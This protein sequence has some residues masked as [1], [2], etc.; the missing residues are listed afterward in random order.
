MLS[1]SSLS[2]LFSGPGWKKN[3]TLSKVL[4]ERVQSAV[5]L[6]QSGKAKQ[7]LLSGENRWIY[8][9]E[10]LG[11]KKTA[12]EMGVN[13]EKI[14]IDHDG[15]RSLATCLNARDQFGAT[16]AILITQSFHLPRV[17]FLARSIGIHAVGVAATHENHRLDDVLW[18]ELREIPATLR[19]IFDVLSL[20]A[21]KPRGRA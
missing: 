5:W 6:R 21:S 1:P 19:A 11:M 3:G 14:L 7:I 18:W 10:P 9:D 20:R 13:S 15:F 8:Y 12:L 4:R 17:L 2:Q 16:E